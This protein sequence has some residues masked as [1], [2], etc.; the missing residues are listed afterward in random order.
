MTPTHKII[1]RVAFD[2]FR[3]WTK[4]ATEKYP[5][6]DF[7]I[8]DE[9]ELVNDTKDAI[10]EALKTLFLSEKDEDRQNMSWCIGYVKGFIKGNLRAKWFSDYVLT[11]TDNYRYMMAIKSILEYVRVDSDLSWRL[12]NIHRELLKLTNLEQI[13]PQTQIDVDFFQK[14]DH[15]PDKKSGIVIQTLENLRVTLIKK[16]FNESS[17]DIPEKNYFSSEEI[18]SFIEKWQVSK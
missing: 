17:L 8:K 15:V 6:M 4:A 2:L 5:D 7:T 16:L 11:Q 3:D 9:T 13:K 10:S 18:Q 14:L 1:Q 12:D